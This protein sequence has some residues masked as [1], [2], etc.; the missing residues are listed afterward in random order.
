MR[1][2][3]YAPAIATPKVGGYIA[4]GVLKANTS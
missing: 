1:S 3:A 2:F 4:L